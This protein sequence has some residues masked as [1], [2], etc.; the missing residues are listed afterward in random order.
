MTSWIIESITQLAQIG[1][2]IGIIGGACW[3]A[4]L[5]YQKREA[6]TQLKMVENKTTG[7]VRGI[8]KV[9]QYFACKIKEK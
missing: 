3:A 4:Y 1:M 8:S 6:S 2:I 5:I 9:A 7:F